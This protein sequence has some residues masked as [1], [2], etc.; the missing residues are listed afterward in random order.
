MSAAN[1]AALIKKIHRTLKA[2]YP[3][4]QLPIKDRPLA[5]H[6]LY[7]CCL[8]NSTS[9]QASEAFGKLQT[10]YIEWNEIRVSSTKELAEVM[11][12]LTDP[13]AAAHRIRRTLHNLYESFY[14]YDIDFL[15]KENLGKAQ[16]TI[17]SFQGKAKKMLDFVVDYVTQNGLGGHCIPLNLEAYEILLILDIIS[18]NE[19]RFKKVPGLERA[20]SKNKGAEF[21]ALM[22]AFSV[23]F[24][25]NPY[26]PKLHELLL[27]INPKCK[28][29]LPVEPIEEPEADK[30]S[31]E[32]AAAKQETKSSQSSKKSKDPAKKKATTK[33]KGKPN[34][35]K[36]NSSN[37][38]TKKRPAPKKETPAKPTSKKA[39]AKTSKT[40]LP[41]TKAVK[42]TTRKQKSK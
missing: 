22:H 18:K 27:K 42:K 31:E 38:T 35:K 11:D 25:A 9:D 8:E 30:S 5:E 36:K 10:L 34:T 15:T 24:A 32:S 26:D 12:C 16:K 29:N 4:F 2:A 40:K 14:D 6:I 1:R 37:T 39:A 13:A 23:D 3:K 19:R 7:A 33:A 28:D 17:K 41:A 20:I 21:G